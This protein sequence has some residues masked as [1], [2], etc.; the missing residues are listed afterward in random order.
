MEPQSGGPLLG[1]PF[2]RDGDFATMPN[3]EPSSELTQWKYSRSKDW[4]WS[5][6]G[7]G[8][9]GWRRGSRARRPQVRSPAE[10]PARAGGSEAVVADAPSAQGVRR[11]VAD[12]D[13]DRLT[14]SK[15]RVQRRCALWLD[16]DHP[17]PARR[18]RS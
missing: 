13:V 4:T 6:V 11:D 14:G 12:L 9:R 2:D 5:C 15:R 10:G 3:S 7:N 18:T 16:G 8:P 1:R 17:D